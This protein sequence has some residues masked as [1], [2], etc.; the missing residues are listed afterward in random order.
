MGAAGAR[1]ASS[2]VAVIVAPVEVCACGVS[3][4]TVVSD[5]DAQVDIHRVTGARGIDRGEGGSVE[6][7]AGGRG[8]G[9]CGSPAVRSSD[10]AP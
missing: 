5:M 3:Q 1:A 2:S 4:G 9:G 6:R 7:R 8:R 10:L